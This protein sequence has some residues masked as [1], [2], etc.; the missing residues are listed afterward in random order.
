M[1]KRIHPTFS[2]DL[3]EA[4]ELLRERRMYRNVSEY[5]AGLVRYDAISQREHLLTAE[6]AA[7]GGHERDLLDAGLLE[8]VKSGE[9]VRGS[10]LKAQ[11]HDIVKEIYGRDPE[12]PPTIPEVAKELGR[13]LS[14]ECRGKKNG[15]KR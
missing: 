13:K 14:A 4:A 1:S 9:T 11:I 12:K 8:K 10:W 5:L 15:T 3:Y 7:L 6:W 2:D